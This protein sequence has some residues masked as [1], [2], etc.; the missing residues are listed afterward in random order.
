MNT[1]G[2]RR[3]AFVG[4]TFAAAGSV[5]FGS[6][7]RAQLAVPKRP[8]TLSLVDIAGDLAL[9]Q[10]VIENYARAKPDLVS[11]FVFTK[12]PM[13]ELPGKLRA[14]QDANRSDI[15]LV[16]T[17]YDGATIGI[18][19]NLWLP[20]LPAYT[21]LLPRLDEIYLPGAR[22][23][24]EQLQG[25][26]ICIAYSPYG[27]LLEYMPDN[28]GIVPRTA[29]DLMAWC[30][31]HQNRFIYARPANSGP[32]R[33][34]ITGLPYV[35]GDSDPTDP[36]KGWDKT[37][38]YL[39][40]IGEHIE[41]YPAGT[42]AV[43]KELGEGSRDMMPTTTGWD[44]NPRALGIMPKEAKVFALEGFHWVSDAHCWCV[45]KGVGPEKLAVILD[46]MN[47]MLTPRQQA[48]IFGDGYF[49]PGPA[50]KD[51]TLDMAPEESRN[52]IKEFG[53]PEYAELIAN[54]PQEPPLSAAATTAAFKI[55]D[56]RIGGARK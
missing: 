52:V 35:L 42:G 44:I 53:R 45:P 4:V 22:R 19:Q 34:F 24:Q 26:A 46:L 23:I 2:I 1:S 30:R 41:Y 43:I 38:S 7:A 39:K 29:A 9:T 56:E 3:R 40:A 50:V 51:T 15:D 25:Q 47:F 18:E 21:D 37:W 48:Y 5:A 12:A 54:N 28:I 8:V 27:S 6:E 55:W 16:L 31:E 49:Y 33:S 36:V 11:R 32:G 20:L 17:G 10:R 13:P 14:Q